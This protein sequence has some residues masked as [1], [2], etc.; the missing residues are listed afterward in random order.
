MNLT[1]LSPETISKV[2]EVRFQPETPQEYDRLDTALTAISNSE[3]FAK[4]TLGGRNLAVVNAVQR[5]IARHKKILSADERVGFKE[6]LIA[7]VRAVIG[8]RPRE[9]EAA[10]SNEVTPHNATREDDTEARKVANALLA[11][12]INGVDELES[13]EKYLGSVSVHEILD[14]WLQAEVEGASAEKLRVYGRAFFD[15]RPPAQLVEY[16]YTAGY[17]LEGFGRE[18]DLY[19]D[20]LAPYRRPPSTRS[21]VEGRAYQAGP[22][23]S[24]FEEESVRFQNPSG[25]TR[26]IG[27]EY[28][29]TEEEARN[30]VIRAH[31]RAVN[32]ILVNNLHVDHFLM[33]AFGSKMVLHALDSARRGNQMSIDKVLPLESKI[34]FFTDLV[35]RIVDSQ[36]DLLSPEEFARLEELAKG[37]F[38]RDS[39]VK[40]KAESLSIAVNARSVRKGIHREIKGAAA[41]TAGGLFGK[42][43]EDFQE[44]VIKSVEDLVIEYAQEGGFPLVEF[45]LKELP[46]HEIALFWIRAKLM[47]EPKAIKELYRAAFLEVGPPQELVGILG[48]ELDSY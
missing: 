22:D 42:A 31:A 17:N 13:L 28:T 32:M 6:A 14:N 19:Q 29:F 41:E 45:S 30:P 21:T 2:D 11:Q 33:D 15:K 3:K 47:C 12:E 24:G 20:V 35:Q 16:V 10:A 1:R 9:P 25:A 26:Q 36:R 34:A 8:E 43:F 27:V 38:D 23:L 44:S 7:H 18:L 5:E 4:S 46:A 48:G 40:R 37:I 39:L